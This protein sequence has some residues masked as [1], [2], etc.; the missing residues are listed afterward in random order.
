[1]KFL[2][3]YVERCKVD[4]RFRIKSSFVIGGVVAII[5]IIFNLIT[6]L[7][8]KLSIISGIT[9]GILWIPFSYLFIRQAL[10]F[11][12]KRIEYEKMQL[13]L[14]RAEKRKRTEEKFKKKN[15]RRA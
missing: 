2:V 11:R 5:S 9:L 7:E 6:G 13:E 3:W 15:I 1:M 12:E 8:F 10:K 4:R 14:E